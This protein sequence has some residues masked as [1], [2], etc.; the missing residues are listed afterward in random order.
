MKRARVF[1][2]ICIGGLGALLIGVGVWYARRHNVAVLNTQ[3]TVGNAERRMIVFA[4][5]LSL[6]IVLPV[7]ALTFGIAWRYRAGNK[8][9]TY[10][11]DMDRNR[12]FET[13]WWVIPSVLITI[14]SVVAWRGSHQLDPY[15]PL[16]SSA[17]PLTIQVIALDWK[18]LFIYPDQHIATVN[19]VQFPAG[20]PVTFDITSDA[21]MN[22]FW[23]PQLGGQIYAMS[24]MSSQLHLMADHA[25]D[26]RG[27]SSNISGKG[28]AGMTFTARASSMSGFNA[29]VHTVQQSPQRL[30][31]AAYSALARPSENNPPA[32]YT[33]QAKDLYNQVMMKYM[34]PM[35]SSS[36]SAGTGQDMAGMD[37]SGGMN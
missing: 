28:F 11:P 35:G 34:M 19:M 4:A 29:W 31:Q 1:G 20:T 6:V 12:W 13:A 14:L 17:K 9:A 22:A 25:G 16:N 18:W 23:I 3:G 7:F 5:L 36:S 10:R 21:P 30:D 8:K 26:Y 37:M 33:L 15:R 27:S 24:G 32:Y 2:I